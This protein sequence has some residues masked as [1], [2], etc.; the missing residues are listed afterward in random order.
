MSEE[1]KKLNV[2]QRAE[3]FRKE[4]AELVEKWGIDLRAT[5]QPMLNMVDKV[6]PKED[7]KK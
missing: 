6:K 4:Y 3:G 5:V 1:I 2:E 7:G